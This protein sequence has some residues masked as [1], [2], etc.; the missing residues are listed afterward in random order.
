[1][2]MSAVLR[3]F[4]D[5][6][7]QQCHEEVEQKIDDLPRIRNQNDT[8][9]KSSS[10]A[11]QGVQRL[12]QNDSDAVT[13][14][15]LSMVRMLDKLQE[16]HQGLFDAI[17]SVLLQHV[18]ESMALHL[19][20]L[21]GHDFTTNHAIPGGLIEVK[22]NG[23]WDAISAA[24]IEAPF[25]VQLLKGLLQTNGPKNM[26]QTNTAVLEALQTSLLQGVFGDDDEVPWYEAC[27]NAVPHLRTI[28]KADPDA[29]LYYEDRD[30]D[31]FL[32]QVWEL[33]GWDIMLG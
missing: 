13:S 4:L 11:V 7:R 2:S 16:K 32:T 6:L 1:M 22:R 26:I 14:G 15:L 18:G 23:V 5:Y 29:E 3:F 20:G 24:K 28:E 21:L 30:D 10:K 27:S 31:W 17:V 25:L 19:W 12:S 8:G 33:L 9:G